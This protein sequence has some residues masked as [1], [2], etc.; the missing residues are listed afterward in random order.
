MR[1]AE[2]MDQIA[3]IREQVARAE[4]FRG[5]RAATTAFSGVVAI[6]ASYV[7]AILTRNS[8]ITDGTYLAVWCGAAGLCLL[9][10]GL[11]V[12]WR[13]RRS[14]SLLQRDL[15]WSAVEHFMP[16]LTAGGLLTLVLYQF[17]F[18]TIWMLPGLWMILFGLGI[19]ASRRL[20]PRFSGLIA[21]Y[22]LASGLFVLSLREWAAFNPWTMGAVFGLGQFMAAGLLRS[23]ER[24]DAV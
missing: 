16:A 12:A 13:V 22:Y 17:A 7:T 23:T 3:L 9:V 14:Q 18:E 5:Y 24:A 1:I 2:A 21:G 20:L 4:M 15:T 19:H 6:V 10:V 11:D 8:A